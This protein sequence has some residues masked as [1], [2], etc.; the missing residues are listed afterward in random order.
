MITQVG[1]T[2]GRLCAEKK[3]AGFRKAKKQSRVTQKLLLQGLCVS[4]DGS[5][6]KTSI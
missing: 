2:D 6:Q 3:K 5:T 4:M 1:A